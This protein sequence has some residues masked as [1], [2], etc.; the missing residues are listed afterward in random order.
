MMPGSQLTEAP[1]PIVRVV[2]RWPPGSRGTRDGQRP[3]PGAP[4]WFATT[5]LLRH[6]GS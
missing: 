3:V 2:I 6:S 1:A 4:A 5:D